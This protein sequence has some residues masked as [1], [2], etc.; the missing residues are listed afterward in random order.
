M[1]P[2]PSKSWNPLFFQ[3]EA[4]DP[5]PQGSGSLPPS[6][7][8]SSVLGPHQTCPWKYRSLERGA[9]WGFSLSVASI[10]WMEG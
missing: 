8:L 3:A 2:H 5:C 10:A 7:G 4:Q 1:P 9:P 6:A